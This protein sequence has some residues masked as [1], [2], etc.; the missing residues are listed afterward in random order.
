MIQPPTETDCEK[1]WLPIPETNSILY[2]WHPLQVGVI[3]D[4]SL[5]VQSTHSTPWFFKHLR[6]SAVPIRQGSELWALTHYVEYSQ[7]RKYFHCIVAI[8]GEDYTPRRMTLP[9]TFKSTGIEYCLGWSL[10]DDGLTFVFSSWDDN[11]CMTT[12][13]ISQFEWVSL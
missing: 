8:D 3:R 6:G 12:A 13:P 1:N 9:F 5:L 11:P 2:T 7:P 10:A 4:K